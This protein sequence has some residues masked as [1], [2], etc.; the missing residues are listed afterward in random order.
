VQL[1]SECLTYV[2]RLGDDGGAVMATARAT[3]END[4]VVRRGTNSSS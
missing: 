4:N 3:K 1:T 2:A